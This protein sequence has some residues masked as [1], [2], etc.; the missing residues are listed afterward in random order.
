[1]RNISFPLLTAARREGNVH[2]IETINYG[3]SISICSAII[4]F[5]EAYGIIYIT[6][7]QARGIDG[8]HNVRLTPQCTNGAGFAL[9]LTN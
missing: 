6:V 5:S 8:C 7:P 2:I 1:V 4:I 9:N 3:M